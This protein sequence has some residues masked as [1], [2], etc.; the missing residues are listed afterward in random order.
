MAVKLH[1][2]VMRDARD[3]IHSF[4]VIMFRL[5]EFIETLIEEFN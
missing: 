5:L 2:R 3:V 4:R 1:S